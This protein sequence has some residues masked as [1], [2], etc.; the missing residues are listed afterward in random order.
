MEILS[1]YFQA[2]VRARAGR[3]FDYKCLRCLL[4]ESDSFI[5]NLWPVRSKDVEGN[6][7]KQR[8]IDT[9]VPLLNVQDDAFFFSSLFT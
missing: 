4:V 2:A 6:D 1:Q 5:I 9:N 3:S 7:V 8:E